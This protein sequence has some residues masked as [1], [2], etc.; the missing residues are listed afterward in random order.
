[1]L[2]PAPHSLRR[3]LHGFVLAAFACAAL[4]CWDGL[5]RP[6]NVLFS[7]APNSAPSEEEKGEGEREGVE[8]VEA[9]F[10]PGGSQRRNL[11]RYVAPPG[12]FLSTTLAPRALSLSISPASP[13]DALVAAGAGQFQRC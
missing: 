4:G 6:A 9:V 10:P 1:M 7:A 3:Y 2:T 12:E 5:A 8:T 11:S 13:A